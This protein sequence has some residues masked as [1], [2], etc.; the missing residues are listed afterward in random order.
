MQ[1]IACM[2]LKPG[3]EL[4]EDAI[5]YTNEI[6]LKANTILD[7]NAIEKLTRHSIMCVSIKEQIDYAT[8]H[9]EKVRYSKSFQQFEVVY[10]NNLNAYKYIINDFLENDKPINTDYL[11]QIHDNIANCSPTREKLID[12]LYNML[13]TED[14]MTYAHCLNSALISNV[15]GT[16]LGLS[17]SEIRLLTLCGFFYDIGKLKLPNNI[18]WKPDKL[19]AFEY[20]WVKTHT[21]IGY[22]LIK[23]L[24]L[25]QHI[26][27][28][29]L[30][31]HERC[32]GSGY[33]NHLH[34][35]DIGLFTKYIAIVDSYEAMT[36]ARTYRSS[37]NPFQVIANFERTGFEK[38]GITIVSNILEHIANDQLGM[39]VRLSND[40][41]GSVILINKNHLSKPLIK[42]DDTIVDLSVCDSL[43]IVAIL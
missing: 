40:Q 20:N 22:D 1:T 7:K 28:A 19:S 16:W 39:T 30:M 3:M 43:D 42:C 25:D 29:T 5:S 10:Q 12:M 38:Y 33:P 15:F 6:I 14:N 17:D 32:D 41:I 13:P 4:A 31:H 21:K 11:L 27:D 23:R 9:F 2:A 24:P 37:L 26:L 8:T 36:S 34:D 18:L 35:D